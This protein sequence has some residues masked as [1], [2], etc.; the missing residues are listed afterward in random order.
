MS[1]P[2]TTPA[3]SPAADSSQPAGSAQPGSPLPAS[4]SDI[5]ARCPGIDTSQA[6]DALFV[7]DQLRQNA[8]ADAAGNT[9]VLTQIARKDAARQELD[10]LRA[11]QAAAP[12]QP[13]A[14]D[15]APQG[16]KPPKGAG[17]GLEPVSDATGS[18][19]DYSDPA[20]LFNQLVQDRIKAGNSRSKAVAHVVRNNPDLHQAYLA[21]VN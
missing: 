16:H 21:S 7:A 3:H 18:A 10:E 2:V 1:D 12:Q 9:W 11:A 8:T 4:F 14:T 17:T 13:A 20:T 19:G 6:E 15:N 5:V